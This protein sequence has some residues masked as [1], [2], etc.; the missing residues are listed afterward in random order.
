MIERPPWRP[1]RLLVVVIAA[2]AAWVVVAL[3]RHP[4]FQPGY[5]LRTAAPVLA[6]LI[7]AG[8]THLVARLRQ[9][10]DVDGEF[11]PGGRALFLGV[12]MLVVT[13]LAWLV[14]SHALPATINAFVGVPR[15][16]PGVV[17]RRMPLANDPDC[18]FRLEVSSA[19]SRSGSI[20]RAMDEC[21]AEALWNEA[22]AG[23][24]LTLRLVASAVG[25][26]LVGVSP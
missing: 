17:A 19:S 20:S 24:A 15:S 11:N 1:G 18:R 13:A 8:F 5:A 9:R 23:N 12:V 4:G 2:S 16:E 21:V 6:L 14:V 25:A 22:A 3:A 7:G 26:E 10:V